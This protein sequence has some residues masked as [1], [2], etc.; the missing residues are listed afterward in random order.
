MS[1][2]LH[3]PNALTIGF[4]QVTISVILFTVLFA[5]QIIIC[6]R[7]A[8]HVSL[9]LSC[10][11]NLSAL[12]GDFEKFIVPVICFLVIFF[13]P[14]FLTRY[15]FVS[16]CHRFRLLC[17]YGVLADFEQVIILILLYLALFVY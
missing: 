8:A 17:I 15:R 1:F 7:S 3:D 4:E 9:V 2:R 13:L 5:N 14:C 11:L 10:L 12:V 16:C 6:S